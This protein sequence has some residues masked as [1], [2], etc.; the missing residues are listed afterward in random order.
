MPVKAAPLQVGEE[1][2]IVP[3]PRLRRRIRRS[4]A[5]VRFGSWRRVFGAVER[6]RLR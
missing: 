6:E 2:M 1:V 5:M 3:D 4:A